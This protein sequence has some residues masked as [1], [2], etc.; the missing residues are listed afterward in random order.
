MKSHASDS[1]LQRFHSNR[2]LQAMSHVA[3]PVSLGEDIIMESGINE[4]PVGKVL[5]V[6]HNLAITDLHPGHCV[7]VVLNRCSELICH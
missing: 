2:M 6:S 7:D 3:F 4:Q 1:D 5:P